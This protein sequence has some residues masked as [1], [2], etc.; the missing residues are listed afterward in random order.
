MVITYKSGFQQGH[1]TRQYG[2]YRQGLWTIRVQQ[3]SAAAAAA[4]A[5]LCRGTVKA[6]NMDSKRQ[7]VAVYA[8][9]MGTGYA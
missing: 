7:D 6:H 3:S 9:D 1:R 2:H 5:E 4:A 8:Q